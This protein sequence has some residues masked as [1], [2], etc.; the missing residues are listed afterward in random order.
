ML[1]TTRDLQ[2]TQCSMLVQQALGRLDMTN[3]RSFTSATPPDPELEP[4]KVAHTVQKAFNRY[5][6][7]NKS[8]PAIAKTSAHLI[9][10]FTSI[11]IQSRLRSKFPFFAGRHVIQQPR[12]STTLEN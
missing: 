9:F 10:I 4:D 3:R 8:K 12:S 2:R 6:F 11:L 5:V 7:S 1:V